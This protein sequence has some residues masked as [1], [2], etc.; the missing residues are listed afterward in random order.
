MIV[1]VAGGDARNA[2]LVPMLRA[3]GCMARAVAL[4]RAEVPGLP[5][6]PPEEIG[7]ADALVLNSPLKTPLSGLEISLEALLAA[8][9]PARG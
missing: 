1:Y 6:A 3:R 5:L 9:V 2:W 8:S 4:E 7:D